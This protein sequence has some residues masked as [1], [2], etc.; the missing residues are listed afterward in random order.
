MRRR[1]ALSLAL[2][3]L[4]LAA[5]GAWLPAKAQLAQV[6][7]H[8][9]WDRT[10]EEGGPQRPW[11]WADTHPVARLRAPVQEVDL[12]VLAGA[13][14]SSLAFGP[15]HVAHSGAPGS[16]DTIVFGGHRDTH[17]DFLQRLD[18]GDALEVQ[19]T[20]GR[21]RRYLVARTEV[22]DISDSVLRI[23]SDSDSLAL[24]TCYPFAALAPGGTQRFVVSATGVAL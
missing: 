20:D 10:L 17:F 14:G 9:A 23:E 8:R 12:I 4:A 18:V 11:P 6:L 5:H 13:T 21:V 7:L 22:A 3:A 2:A 15:G 16:H 24:V 1:L 19:D